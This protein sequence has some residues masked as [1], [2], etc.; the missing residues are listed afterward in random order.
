MQII[1]DTIKL[2]SDSKEPLSNAF[3]KA[4]VIAHKLQDEEFS[5][6]VK[7]EIQGYGAA[8]TIPEYRST[9]IIPYGTLENSARTYKKFKLPTGG[10]PE[11]YKQDFLTSNLNKSIAVI[12]EFEK[13]AS[14][15]TAVI[16]PG[17]YQFLVEGI[18]PSYTLIKAW[19][20]IPAGTF[21]QIINNVRS[22]L[23]DLL[24]N[25]SDRLPDSLQEKDLKEMSKVYDFNNMFKGTVFGENSNINFAIGTGN[26]TSINVTSVKKNDLNSLISELK[27]HNISEADLSELKEAI[28]TDKNNKEDTTKNFGSR[29]RGWLGSMISKAGTPALEISTQVAAGCLTSALSNF[30][31]LTS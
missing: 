28:A 4:Q 6:W 13:N 22:R 1:E 19:G 25:L 27:K 18:D 29:V 9:N 10:I 30:Y 24:L 12:E 11:K 23:L 17:L 26:Q 14:G 7:N 20:E 21:T 2:L 3:I 31:G 8:D 16:D 15:L 5:Q